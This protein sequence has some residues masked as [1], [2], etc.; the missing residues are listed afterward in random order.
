MIFKEQTCLSEFLNCIGP[1]HL[2]KTEK[3]SNCGSDCIVHQLLKK[4]NSQQWCSYLVAVV[5]LF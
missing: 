2:G 5:G 3:G 1:V 4:N